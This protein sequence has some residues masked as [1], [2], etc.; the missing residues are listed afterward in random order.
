MKTKFFLAILGI[1]ILFSCNSKSD[2][3][4]E[5]EKPADKKTEVQSVST[6]SGDNLITFMVNNEQVNSSGWNIGFF[7]F[8]DGRGK[9]LNVASN[10]HQNPKTLNININ[11]N[12]PG[13]YPFQY[14][15]DDIKTSGIAYGSYKPDYMNDITN[16]YSFRDG[17][18][19]IVSVDTTARLLN[20]TFHGTAKN[21]KGETVTITNGQV[22]NGRLNPGITKY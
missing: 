5:K 4:S 13:T 2:S 7:D 20:A 18:F 15:L 16:S 21:R 9:G 22:I 10:M 1:S 14:G 8:G 6:N 12:K 19:V 17:E 3:N 11:G